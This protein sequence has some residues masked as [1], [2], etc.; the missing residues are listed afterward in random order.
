MKKKKKRKRGEKRKSRKWQIIAITDD[1]RLGDFETVL[2]NIPDGSVDLILTDPPYPLE[3][4]DCWSKLSKF[5]KRVLKPNGFCITYSG[6]LNLSEVLKRMSEN[7]DY[8]WCFALIHTG[9]RQLIMPRNIFC[10]WKPLLV[11]Q[12]GLK[13][14]DTPIDDFIIGTGREKKEH[15]WQQA[16]KELN[17]I[18]E[19]F[20]NPGD[21]IVEPFAGGGTTI[22]AAKKLKRNIIAAEIDEET[23]NIA[24]NRLNENN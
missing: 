11:F 22:I 16:E 9:T 2:A 23:Y 10:G 6:Q 4:I 1:F 21:L 14:I 8:Y 15:D 18:I 17:Q 13:K 5:A 3:F 24:K 20:T 7:L 19:K 12:N